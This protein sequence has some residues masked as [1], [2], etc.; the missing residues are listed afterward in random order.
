MPFILRK[1][2]NLSK[3]KIVMLF[4]NTILVYCT[5]IFIGIICTQTQ[6]FGAKYQL[7]QTLFYSSIF[8]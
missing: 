6:A 7:I 4:S 2:T 8:S 3:L 5:L 1:L